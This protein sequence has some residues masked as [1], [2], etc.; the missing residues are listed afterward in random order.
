MSK[1]PLIRPK[2]IA[3]SQDRYTGAQWG[4]PS[5]RTLGSVPDIVR[6]QWGS[7]SGRTLGS[8]PDIV[9]VAGVPL[10]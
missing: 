2:F 7:P 8:V 5:G 4:S 9:R 6:A 1:S 10:C 3:I